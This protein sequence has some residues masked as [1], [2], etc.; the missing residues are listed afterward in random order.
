MAIR[1]DLTK[2]KAFPVS[3]K[4]GIYFISAAWVGH[5]IFFCAYFF[6]RTGN[7]PGDLFLRHFLLGSAICFFL[8]RQKAWARW[9]GIMGNLI[10]LI[11]YIVWI[12]SFQ[13]H[14]LE[15][16]IMV[17]IMVLFSLSTYHLFRKESSVFFKS[18]QEDST[19]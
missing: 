2:I 8:I 19:E 11:Y 17:S 1:E 15:A 14:I 7:I 6:R 5:W 12:F 10:I 13:M 18:Q 3:V 4:Y 9:L 16:A